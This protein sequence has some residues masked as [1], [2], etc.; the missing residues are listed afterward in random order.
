MSG[1][2]AATALLLIAYLAGCVAEIH[3]IVQSDLKDEDVSNLS[4]ESSHQLLL[5]QLSKRN[6]PEMMFECR[7]EMY[8][9]I[10]DNDFYR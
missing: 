5:K 8:T 3:W 4:R 7:N 10:T 1:I 6:I 2:R 9:M